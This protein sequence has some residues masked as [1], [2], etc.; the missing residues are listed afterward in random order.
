MPATRR[1]PRD[2]DVTPEERRCEI[3]AIIAAALARLVQA[4]RKPAIPR[5]SA[6]TSMPAEKL[7]ESAEIGLE[8]SGETRL[9]VPAG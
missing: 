2:S 7:S 6:S 4:D 5:P 8:L 9:S 1:S 3:I